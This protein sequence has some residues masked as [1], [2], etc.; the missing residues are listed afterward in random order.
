[1]VLITLAGIPTAIELAGT[2]LST[3][4]PAPIMAFSPIV[5]PAKTETPAPSQALFL[6]PFVSKIRHP[7]L[8]SDK[9]LFARNAGFLNGGPNGLF[10]I[11]SGGRVD[12]SVAGL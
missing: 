1:M 11:V 6:G 4:A 5:T 9:D 2:S 8:R 3:T 7:Q 12:H 10:V